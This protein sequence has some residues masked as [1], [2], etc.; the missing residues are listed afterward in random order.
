VAS[1]RGLILANLMLITLREFKQ[2]VIGMMK[3]EAG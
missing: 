1:K 3:D 2:K